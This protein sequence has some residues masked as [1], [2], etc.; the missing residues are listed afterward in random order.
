MSA[1]DGKP[2]FAPGTLGCHEA[3]H[4]ASFLADAVDRELR[5]H[6]AIVRNPEW[7][8]LAE[9]ATQALADLYNRIAGEHC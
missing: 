4:M 5:S 9:T 3:L 8:Q 1:D 6:P 7:R 2:D